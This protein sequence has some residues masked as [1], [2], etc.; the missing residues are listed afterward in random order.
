M[1]TV[2]DQVLKSS[3]VFVRY[4]E[5]PAVAL[6][7]LNIRPRARHKL[8][9]DEIEVGQKVMVNYNYDEPDARGYWYDA[10]VTNKQSTRTIKTVECTVFI[11]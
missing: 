9:M 10:I 1:V 5:D 6:T 3:N 8:P 2:N 4:E 7:V 11:G